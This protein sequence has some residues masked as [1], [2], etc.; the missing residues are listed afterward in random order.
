MICSIDGCTRY[1]PAVTADVN[2]KSL[3]EAC[4]KHGA[5]LK[6]CSHDECTTTTLAVNERR[7]LHKTWSKESEKDYCSYEGCTNIR[8][9][10]GVCTKHGMMRF[11]AMKVAQGF[12]LGMGQRE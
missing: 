6:T 12:V 5:A 1:I 3:T 2:A 10:G 8:V 11:V 7:S 9:Q 4:V